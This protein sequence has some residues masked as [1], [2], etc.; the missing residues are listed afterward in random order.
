VTLLSEQENK[1]NSSQP[2]RS[3]ARKLMIALVALSLLIVIAALVVGTSS[4]KKKI[5]LPAVTF[6]KATG[7]SLDSA[8]GT[9]KKPG[10]ATVIVFFAS[11]CEPCKKELPALSAYVRAHENKNVDV[12]GLDGREDQPRDGIAFV[13]NAGFT[14]TVVVDPNYD[15]VSG[16][17]SLPGFPD[18][19]FVGSDGEMIER[20]IG[21]LSVKDFATSYQDLVERSQGE[22]A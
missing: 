17:F 6:T 10:K 7:G 4:S 8:W 5:F 3:L 16:L 19:I 18:T 1:T 15:L 20:H 2:H 14:N 12:L 11:W 21:P 22:D 9:P 13:K